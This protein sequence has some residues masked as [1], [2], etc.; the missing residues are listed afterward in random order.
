MDIT[1]WSIGPLET[2]CYLLTAN[3]EAVLIDPGWELPELAAKLAGTKLKYIVATHAHLDHI[4]GLDAVRAERHAEVCLGKGDVICLGS[5]AEQAQ[6]I[7]FPSPPMIK[8]ER[9]L[10]GGEELE[11][12]GEKLRVLDTPG[13]TPGHI[14]LLSSAGVFVGDVLFAGSVGRTDLPMADTQQLLMSIRDELLALPD[15][16]VVFPGHGPATTIGEERASNPFLQDLL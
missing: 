5:L 11:F 3:G 14:S 7:G 9:E 15:E 12:G 10:S 2:N 6:R 8:V 1:S 4:Y 13:H 16:T